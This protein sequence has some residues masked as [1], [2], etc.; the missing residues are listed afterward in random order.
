M[1]IVFNEKGLHDF[2]PPFLV[3]EFYNHNATI[4]KVFV[5]GDVTYVQKR[6]SLP[7]VPSDRK[8]LFNCFIFIRP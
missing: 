6:K 5:V 4:F 7:N 3:Q 1:G 2:Q 8:I